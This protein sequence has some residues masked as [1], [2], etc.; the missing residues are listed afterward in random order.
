MKLNKTACGIQILQYLT[1]VGSE[2]RAELALPPSV[3][4]DIDLLYTFPLPPRI[5][6]N[7]AENVIFDTERTWYYYLAE[8]ASRH[9]TNR[10]LQSQSSYQVNPK[11]LRLML[12]DLDMFNT[13]LDQWYTSLPAV[14]SFE[15]P[16]GE[17]IPPVIDDL[18]FILRGRYLMMRELMYRPFVELCIEHTFAGLEVDS[19]DKVASLASHCLQDAVYRLQVATFFRHHGLWYNLRNLVAYAMLLIATERAQS[20]PDRYAAQRI[21]LPRNWRHRIDGAL[22]RA[23]TYTQE[24]AGGTAE[25]FALLWE[26]LGDPG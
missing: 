22:A 23:E 5:E 25:I 19:V 12:S 7:V 1:W 21:I 24:P 4:S 6:L 26:R 15:L 8:I 10:L 16:D 9:L 13:Q 17:Y 3:L 11:N 2:L 20:R 18:R 14:I